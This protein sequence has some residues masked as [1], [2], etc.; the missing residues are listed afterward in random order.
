VRLFLAVVVASTACGRGDGA[1]PAPPASDDEAHQARFEEERRPAAVVAALGLQ[2]G[3]LVADIG[4]GNGR[5]T[6]HLA[7]AVAPNGH[8][9]A[10]DIDSEVL[11]QYLQPT[12]AEAALTDIVEPRVVDADTPG[13]EDGSYDAILLADVDHCFDELRGGR[14]GWLAKAARALDP[15]GLLV[16]S[17]HTEEHARSVAAALDAGFTLD[18]EPAG[19]ATHFI[20]VFRVSGVH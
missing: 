12:I 8:V 19:S 1:P 11:E 2:P 15:S 6:V 20:S 13:L 10:T 16:I 14:V 7:R 5:M 17:N 3:W 9:V 18:S 4:A